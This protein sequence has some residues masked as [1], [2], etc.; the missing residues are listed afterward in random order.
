[1]Y[2][3]QLNEVKITLGDL[4]I[5]GTTLNDHSSQFSIKKVASCRKRLIIYLLTRDV[6]W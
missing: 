1:M 5:E 3:L 6:I 4:K 2:M